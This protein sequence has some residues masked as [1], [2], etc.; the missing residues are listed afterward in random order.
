MLFVND[1]A[2]STS[3]DTGRKRALKL[4]PCLVTISLMTKAVPRNEK[5]FP[6]K[7]LKQ[8][9]VLPFLEV[10]IQNCLHLHSEGEAC[11]KMFFVLIFSICAD[12]YIKLAQS[13]ETDSTD[14]CIKPASVGS[15]V[16]RSIGKHEQRTVRLPASSD[17]SNY[18]LCVGRPIVLG[19]ESEA[20]LIGA[21]ILGAYASQQFSSLSVSVRY[22]FPSRHWCWC[23][24]NARFC[25]Y[26]GTKICLSASSEGPRFPS[27]LMLTLR[28]QVS[29]SS[30]SID[31]ACADVSRCGLCWCVSMWPVL[32]CVDVACADVCR[33][34]MCWYVS[35]DVTCGDVSQCGLR[36][37]VSTWPVLMYVD[38]AWAVCRCGLCWYV[39]VD[40]ACADVYW[41]D[42]CCVSIWP[43][44]L[45]V[46]RCDLCWCV[47]MWPVLIC[48]GRCGLCWYVSMWPVL[49]CVDVACADTCR[50][51]WPVLICVGR[52]GLCWYVSVDVACADVCRC[53]L[54]WRV[55]IDVACV[56][57]ESRWMAV[58]YRTCWQSTDLIA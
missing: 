29:R 13:T 35:V 39:S 40:V 43:V 38:V 56:S 9:A 3:R 26:F 14:L 18:L 47:S 16:H 33:C 45:C 42:L 31:V 20:V 41:C 58:A 34:G 4:L 49:M 30:V 46:G 6:L 28:F 36:W 1:V 53:G 57:L 37:C 10:V 19:K 24:A 2:S 8:D 51:M 11:Q 54:W 17:C 21:G 15:A 5:M 32:M 12:R 52:C 23:Q 48:V 50:S 25:T 44:L 55:L 7:N 22:V 27:Q